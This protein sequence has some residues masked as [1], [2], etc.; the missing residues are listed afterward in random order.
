M[1]CLSDRKA[2][3]SRSPEEESKKQGLADSGE[4]NLVYLRPVVEYRNA[5]QPF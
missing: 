5:S 1:V 2:L 4:T 3:V